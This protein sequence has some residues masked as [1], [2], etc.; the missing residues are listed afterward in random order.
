MYSGE[1]LKMAECE[2]ITDKFSIRKFPDKPVRYN[3]RIL[4]NHVHCMITGVAFFE[5]KMDKFITQ[6][7]RALQDKT[8]MVCGTDEEVTEEGIV[9]RSSS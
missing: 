4:L 7:M 1:K 9:M 2:S 3:Q 8:R 5:A 6:L